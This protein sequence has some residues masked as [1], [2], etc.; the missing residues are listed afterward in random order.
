MPAQ[1]L[2][3]SKA[4]HFPGLDADPGRPQSATLAWEIENDPTLLAAAVDV[5]FDTIE[6]SSAP[7]T[8]VG[9]PPDLSVVFE[10]RK[11]TVPV[12]WAELLPIEQDALIAVLAA[13]KGQ[14]TSAVEQSVLANAETVAPAG[15]T[16]TDKATIATAPL[17]AGKYRLIATGEQALQ[18][19]PTSFL[20]HRAEARLAIE[21]GGVSQAKASHTTIANLPAWFQM[22]ATY[23]AREG[24]RITAKLQHR[25]IGTA[26]ASLLKRAR[27]SVRY[28]EGNEAE[29]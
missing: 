3:F 1:K 12:G 10:L 27:L 21:T 22:I 28:I 25:E 18:Q 16:W 26:N 4:L 14:P 2:T 13:H 11:A 8:G 20:S 19:A 15:T 6:I 9:A 23:N 24:E 17:R 7:D 29:V 5:R